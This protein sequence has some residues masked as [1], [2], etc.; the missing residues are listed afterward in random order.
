MYLA[1]Y[2][3]LLVKLEHLADPRGEPTLDHTNTR[4]RSYADQLSATLS[5]EII[6]RWDETRLETVYQELIYLAE[7]S[8]FRRYDASVPYDHLLDSSVCDSSL[9]LG[10]VKPAHHV[11]I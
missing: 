2:K 10:C 7:Q 4:L 9:L 1:W 6:S 11:W 5:Q 8:F 3:I